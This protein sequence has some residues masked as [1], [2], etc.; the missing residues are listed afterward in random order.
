MEDKPKERTLLESF[1]QEDE[2]ME[3]FRLITAIGDQVHELLHVPTGIRGFFV[4]FT[5]PTDKPKT[6]VIQTYKGEYFAP[7]SEFKPSK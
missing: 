3:K 7:A 5:Y 4:K 6:I 2:Q 1:Q